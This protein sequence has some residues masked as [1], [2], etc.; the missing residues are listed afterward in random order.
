MP[1]DLRGPADP[2]GFA[3]GAEVG[4][5]QCRCL[6]HPQRDRVLAISNAGAANLASLGFTWFLIGRFTGAGIL[7]KDSAHKIL[8]LFGLMNM[9]VSGLVFLKLGWLSVVG[10]FLS[11]FFISIMFPIDVT[12]EL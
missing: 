12:K 4:Y 7:K 6:A 2:R 9:L 5:R 1:H 3:V 11:Y 10:V 8:R